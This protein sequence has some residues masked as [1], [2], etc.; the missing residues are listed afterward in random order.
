MSLEVPFGV[1]TT[2]WALPRSAGGRL[3]PGSR[4]CRTPTAATGER[5]AAAAA[6]GA[7]VGGKAELGAR[8]YQE[9]PMGVQWTILHCLGT[10][11]GHALDAHGMYI[12]YA[13]CFVSHSVA[14]I[15][16]ETD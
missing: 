9:Q 5:R 6:G 16:G 1:R 2:L 15:Q 7:G 13:L 3:L 14:G 11:I 8:T 4:S 12:L 10:S